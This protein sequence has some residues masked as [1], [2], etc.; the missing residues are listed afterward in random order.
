MSAPHFLRS[1]KRDA[2]MG[3]LERNG[4]TLAEPTNPYEVLRYRMWAPG[5]KGR[6]STHIVYKRGNDTLTYQGHSRTHYEAF[7]RGGDA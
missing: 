7:A 6:P 2:F 4:A 5:D 3:W 1:F